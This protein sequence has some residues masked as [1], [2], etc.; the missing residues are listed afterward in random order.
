[1]NVD[2]LF[3]KKMWCAM[4]LGFSLSVQGMESN[5]VVK[6]CCS[7]FGEEVFTSSRSGRCTRREGEYCCQ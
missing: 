5:L 3:S 1:M 2:F 6:Y 4:A 7:G